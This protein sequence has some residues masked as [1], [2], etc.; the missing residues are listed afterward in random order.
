LRLTGEDLDPRTGCDSRIE[1]VEETKTLKLS[2]G[3]ALKLGVGL[4]CRDQDLVEET[5][6]HN[7]DL[8]VCSAVDLSS[9]DPQVVVHKLS[10]FREVRYVSQKKRKLGEDR[11]L[12]AKV[13]AA[14]LLE[15]GFIA[16]VHYTTWLANVVLGKKA[17][18]KW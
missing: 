9:I 18:D 5:L 10:V 1:P 14:K 11:R 7:A 6:K 3:K 13:E 8:L 17:S 15:V 4:S 2:L 16:K 12:T